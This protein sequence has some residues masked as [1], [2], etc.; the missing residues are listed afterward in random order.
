MY[1]IHCGNPPV[2][3]SGDQNSYCR[4]QGYYAIQEMKA[5]RD[6]TNPDYG[7]LSDDNYATVNLGKRDESY[8]LI[9][10]E[11]GFGETDGVPPGATV[12][13]V[14]VE[15]ETHAHVAGYIVTHGLMLTKHGGFNQYWS[16][17]RADD[18]GLNK[19]GTDVDTVYHYGGGVDDKWGYPTLDRG[20]VIKVEFGVVCACENF[21]RTGSFPPVT[22]HVDALK[23]T[24]YYDDGGTADNVSK[25]PGVIVTQD[26]D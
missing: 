3:D 9:A 19:W 8:Y 11:Y 4:H 2:C 16:N 14:K 21:I 13:G 24:I 25:Y 15:P 1:Y 17:S 23:V 18:N 6:W 20:D 5:V 22:A 26:P 12:L 10:T 7:R